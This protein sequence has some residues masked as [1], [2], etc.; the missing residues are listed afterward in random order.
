MNL[1][2]FICW[3]MA[4]TLRLNFLCDN[5]HLSYCQ[6]LDCNFAAVLLNQLISLLRVETNLSSRSR[7]NKDAAILFE[8]LLSL[9]RERWMH[10]SDSWKLNFELVCKKIEKISEIFTFCCCCCWQKKKQLFAWDS[11]RN[12]F[13]AAQTGGWDVT[14]IC[15]ILGWSSFPVIHSHLNSAPGLFIYRSASLKAVITPF[16]L[17]YVSY[18]CKFI[19]ILQW[20]ELIMCWEEQKVSIPL[21]IREEGP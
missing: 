19:V 4:P 12:R 17:H 16:I 5:L 8:E 10:H 15:F 11:P 6:W 13:R 20:Q 3:Q 14:A 18:Y 9:W 2:H 1:Y 7:H 21:R